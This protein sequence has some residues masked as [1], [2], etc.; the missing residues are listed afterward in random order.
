MDEIN[1]NQDI[2]SEKE[3]EP[4]KLKRKIP[5]FLIFIFDL[6]KLVAIAFLVVWPIHY[7][8]FQPFY[9]IGPSMEPSFYDKDYLI[10]T[11]INYRF[12]SPQRGEVV[13]FK[14]PI[15]QGDFLIKRVVGLPEERIIINK[16]KI[17]IYKDSQEFELE[18]GDYLPAGTTTLGE[19]DVTLKNNEYYVLGDNRNM[20]LDSRVF[21]QIKEDSVVGQAWFR[22]WPL[23]DLGFIKTPVFA[24][25]N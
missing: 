21:G 17:N 16:G 10:I 6:I 18:E 15:N 4:I 5:I 8:I 9:V 2:N 25:Q 23:D 12:N 24:D 13:I 11:K 20:S 1:F 7:F 19:V 22:G 14:S 3:E